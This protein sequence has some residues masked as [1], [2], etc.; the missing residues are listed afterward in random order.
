VTADTSTRRTAANDAADPNLAITCAQ[1]DGGDGTYGTRLSDA[2]AAVRRA[3]ARHDPGALA[4]R[5]VVLPELW[6]VGFFHFDD[7]ARVAEPLDGRVVTSIC[8]EARRAGV[9][10]LGGSFVERGADGLHNTTFLVS[11]AGERVLTYRK[12]HLFGHRSAEPELLTAGNSVTCVRTP[13]GRVGAMTCYDLRF[14]ELTRALVDEGAEMILVTSAWPAARIEHWRVLLRARAVENQAW[15]V[16]ANNAGTDAGTPLGGRSAIVAPD[17]D[18]VAEGG[19]DAQDVVAVVDPMRA[20][21]IRRELPFLPD[22]RFGV[23]LTDAGA[24]DRP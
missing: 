21:A 24:P 18:V 12:I 11:A 2:K 7:Y 17:G 22:R 19:S 14:P 8:E 16:A 9:W 20:T 15:I 4:N 10:V 5:L 13:F 6:P 23:H 3:A 1:L